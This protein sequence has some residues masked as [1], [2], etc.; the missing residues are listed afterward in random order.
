MI[1]THGG[2]FAAAAERV[3]ADAD[4]GG[5]AQAGERVGALLYD[6]GEDVGGQSFG[7]GGAS[8]FAPSSP[9]QGK[10]DGAC[11]CGVRQIAHPMSEFDG[12]QSPFDRC[13]GE[14]L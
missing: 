7:L 10:V 8:G 13:Y 1:D 6:L 11:D 4:K 3:V 14:A 12:R 9:A 5:V 2:E